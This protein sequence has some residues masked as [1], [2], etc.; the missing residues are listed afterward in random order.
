[1]RGGAS[2]QWTGSE[3]VPQLQ[4][5]YGYNYHHIDQRTEHH[6]VL[7]TCVSPKPGGPQ[8]QHTAE[9]YAEFTSDSASGQ[10]DRY[11]EHGGNAA[12]GS[13]PEFHYLEQSQYEGDSS[14]FHQTEGQYESEHAHY[15]SE[16]QQYY[17]SD[18]HTARGDHAR[19]VPDG[20]VHFLLSR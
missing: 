11:Y 17:P 19:Y 20:Y 15:G 7:S 13:E 6:S 18:V 16:E 2:Y 8:Q 12:Y 4:T 5:Q 1:M 10:S 14:H 9:V 3:N